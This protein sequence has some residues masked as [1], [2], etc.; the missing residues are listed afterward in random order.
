VP[1]LLQRHPMLSAAVSA[2]ATAGL[3][4][5]LERPVLK[6]APGG[7]SRDD[8][9]RFAPQP[10]ANALTQIVRDHPV[11]TAVVAAATAGLVTYGSAA[12]RRSAAR[13]ASQR[14]AAQRYEEQ[15]ETGGVRDGIDVEGVPLRLPVAGPPTSGGTHPHRASAAHR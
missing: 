5:L 11:L 15:V 8:R 10:T 2:A 13:V 7:P 4:A 9:G 1:N 3:T 12:A 14:S 6:D